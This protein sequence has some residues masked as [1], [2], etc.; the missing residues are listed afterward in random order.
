MKGTVRD[1]AHRRKTS[2]TFLV[3]APE[4]ENKEDDREAVLRD[5]G[6]EFSRVFKVKNP[7]TRSTTVL[8]RTNTHVLGI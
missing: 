3:K 4:G 1:Q 7:Q 6:R 2:S 8:G 5:N